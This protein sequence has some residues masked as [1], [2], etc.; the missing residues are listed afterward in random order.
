[1]SNPPTNIVPVK[2]PP[3]AVDD[4]REATSIAGLQIDVLAND[5]DDGVLID[6]G[7]ATVSINSAV[8]PDLKKPVHGYV[9]VDS[10]SGLVTYFPVTGVAP[11]TIDS[12]EYIVKDS[13]G[14]ESEPA[15]V[16]V[17]YNLPPPSNAIFATVET[18]GS[19]S[20]DVFSVYDGADTV[21]EINTNFAD[22]YNY[23][24]LGFL[25]LADLAS[26]TIP[27]NA[28]GDTGVAAFRYQLDG[29]NGPLTDVI[30]V[31][32]TIEP[33]VNN[34]PDVQDDV[35]AVGLDSEYVDLD[36][37]GN[38]SDDDGINAASL[39]ID[40]STLNLGT[41]SIVNGLVRYTP[42][43]EGLSGVDS[44]TYTVEDNLQEISA[45]AAV[46]VNLAGPLPLAVNDEASVV[47]WE[48]S[49]IH[50]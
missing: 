19:E 14:L 11:G 41:A 48:L 37:L 8:Y 1:M 30:T 22:I 16:S 38:D 40:G 36:V 4:S 12:F 13:D 32:V 31:S 20:I 21:T 17:T 9:E 33:A 7:A 29:A 27:F 25:G 15:T 6:P 26:G 46:T 43:S 3:F 39:A 50:I 2:S 45:I 23:G 49:L 44:F 24:A 42:N 35:F 47:A 5:T 10:S 34:G 18:N 28:Y